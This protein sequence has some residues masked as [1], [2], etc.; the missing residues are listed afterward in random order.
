MD[1][2][3][4]RTVHL[5]LGCIFTPILLFFV[6]TGCLQ[7]FDLHHSRK[8][9]SYKAPEIARIAAEVHQ[10][11]RIYSPESPAASRGFKFFVV[12]MTAGFIFTSIL[13]VIMALK[14]AKPQVVWGCLVAGTILPLL[15]LKFFK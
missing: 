2:K 9:G 4:M 13:G 1:F 5:Y 6:V 14:F 15:F 3:N 7:T 10:H 11:Q 8:N 12:L